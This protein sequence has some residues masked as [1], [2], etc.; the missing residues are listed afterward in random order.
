MD[1][2]AQT[3]KNTDDIGKV[4][5][6]VSELALTMKYEIER[7]KEERENV[8]SM[9]HELRGLNEKIS[10]IAAVQTKLAELEGEVGKL[11]HDIKNVE[12]AQGLAPLLAQK[13]NDLVTD[14]AVLNT[15]DKT[16]KEWRDKHDGAADAMKM[17]VK[18][19]WTVCG[20]G[21][22]SVLGFVLYLYFTNASPTVIRKIGNHE[23]MG[24]LVQ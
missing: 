11:R 10:S 17:A 3:I 5:A 8:K 20:A 4:T 2:E 18:A 13:V 7:G 16:C 6:A 12:N 22:M 14:I 15:N 21:V 1:V 23:Y 19:M 9:V 24:E